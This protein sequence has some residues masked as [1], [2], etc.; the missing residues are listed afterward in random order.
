MELPI[1]SP[2]FQKYLMKYKCVVFPTVYWL[3]CCVY[4]SN[5]TILS[6]KLPIIPFLF[7]QTFKIHRLKH[8]F[9][10]PVPP[11]EIEDLL[12]P[13]PRTKSPPML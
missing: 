10:R 9:L 11:P 13:K 8:T 12:I 3:L 1:S 7:V 5:V 6:G 2:K 4:S